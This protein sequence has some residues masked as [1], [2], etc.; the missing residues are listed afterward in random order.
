[1]FLKRFLLLFLVFI[2]G[3][4]FS[5]D[6]HFSQFYNTF[7]TV[8]P[9]LTGVGATPLR[10]GLIYRNQWS[11]IS[12][13]YKTYTGFADGR[14]TV[15]GLYRT[16]FGIGVSA[17]NDRAGDGVLTNSVAAL[18]FSVTQGFN[19]DNTFLVSMG[20]STG[21]LN[22]SVQLSNLVFD[23]QWDGVKFNPALANNEMVNGQSVFAPDFG[24][25]V[26]VLYEFHGG[27]KLEAGGS[28]HHINK[29]KT[30]FYD[31]D[32]RIDMKMIAHARMELELQRDLIFAPAAFYSV[33][34]NTQE[35]IFGGNL[36]YRFSNLQLIGGLWY[37]W[38]RDVI[39]AVGFNYH[40]YKFTITYDV[41]ISGLH[42]ASNYQ[43]GVELSLVK[44]FRKKTSRYPCSEFK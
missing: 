9:A 43:G 35:I 11:S 16:W 15:K 28:L 33:Q 12:T 6:I 41:N 30:S 39:P 27:L 19:R 10:I 42:P 3:N 17:Y 4:L 25:G 18:S 40:L 36:L 29:P 2:S 21:F 38:G 1:M 23:E 8:N 31:A 7:L 26:V 37:R 44:V 24:F 32:N 20:F 34:A 22:R 14:F 13:P 5:Q